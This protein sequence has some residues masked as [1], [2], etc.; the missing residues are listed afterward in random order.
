MILV[1]PMPTSFPTLRET[2]NAYFPSFSP[3]VQEA[4]R[5]ILDHPDDVALLSMRQL[6]KAAGVHPTTMVRLAQSLGY[7]GFNDLKALFQTR[8]RVSGDDLVAR[9][10]G[11]QSHNG[12]RADLIEE[13]EKNAQNNIYQSLRGGMGDKLEEASRSLLQAKRIFVMGLRISYAP[14]FSFYYAYSMFRHNAMLVDGRAGTVADVLRG[15]GSDDVLLVIAVAPFSRETVRAAH[16]ARKRGAKVITISDSQI[17][18]F[19]G[20]DLQ[21]V[22]RTD[23]QTFFPSMTALSAVV[24]S[25]IALMIAQGGEEVVESVRES[26]AQLDEFG[27]YWESQSPVYAPLNFD[28][29]VK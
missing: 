27:A 22:A 11:L 19:G 12:Q 20:A 24:E 26:K 3:Q 16:Y 10:Q 6:A 17:T 5:Y 14:A 7:D 1:M 15:I 8:M 25:V 2:I 4:A 29:I 23:S 9:A 28:H 18:P 13:I 21:L